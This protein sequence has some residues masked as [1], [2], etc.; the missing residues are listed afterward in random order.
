[1]SPLLIPGLIMVGMV[2]V[3]VLFGWVCYKKF[4]PD[5]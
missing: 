5:N 4:T 1:M 3:S 2:I